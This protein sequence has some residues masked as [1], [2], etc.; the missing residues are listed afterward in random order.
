MHGT[1]TLALGAGLLILAAP[2]AAQGPVTFDEAL[3]LG[4]RS[5]AARVPEQ[6]LAARAAGDEG[7][8]GT[9]QATTVT[10]M[11][12]AVLAPDQEQGF[13]AQL[14]A[15]QGWNLADLGG[16]RRTAAE[17]ERSALSA[18]VR[19]AAL[20][21]RLEAASGWIELA[22][23]EALE[24][25]LEEATAIAATWLERAQR[26]AD[27]GVV[28]GAY[29]ESIRADQALLAQRRIDLEGERTEA[30]L[31][32]ALAIDRSPRPPLTTAGPLPR[33]T[34]PPPRAVRARIATLDDLPEVAVRRLAA[35]AAR[36]R[37]AE[38]SAGYAP[39]LS[40]GAQLEHSYPDGWVLY[41]IVGLQ[42]STFGQERRAVSQA[43][44]SAA[45]EEAELEV[46]RA[47]ARHDL[48]EA[49]HDVAHR[50]E[51]LRV[52]EA[53]LIPALEA[54]TARR[55]RALEAGEG[56]VF[57]WLE[58]RRRLVDA[59]VDRTRV[60]GAEAWASVRLWLLLAELAEGR[61]S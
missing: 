60:R 38:A 11:P 18:Q 14:N 19:A 43:A 37:E 42:L 28:E 51:Q 2:A 57:E 22:T 13:E 61:A 39:I 5:P 24:R 29:L 44:A 3:A 31:R 9:A 54:L 4:P 52:L 12:G 49:M 16:A 32:L 23:V 35:S 15:T 25:E 45:R 58:A 30:G 21:A 55:A 34:L 6:E 46:A 20:R 41:G 27:A 56:T 10:L 50:R 1:S 33:P 36:A 48:E 7:M 17:R 40:V 26:A 53:T 59:N 8:G 47:T